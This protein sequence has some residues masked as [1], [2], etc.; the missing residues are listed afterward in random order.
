MPDKL[1]QEC[2]TLISGC[3][4]IFED[5]REAGV[6]RLPLTSKKTP[7]APHVENAAQPASG[8]E[9][10]ASVPE[11]LAD[12]QQELTRCQGCALKEQRTQTVFGVGNPNARLVLIGEAPN[13]EE[14]KRGEPFVGETGQL[15][16]RILF[17]M[18][19][20][21]E[22]IYI[23]HL[24]KCK[25]PNERGPETA[26]VASCEDFL[27]RQLKIIA[28]EIILSLGGIATQ[29]LLKTDESIS[30]LRGR[31]QTYAGIPLMPT[32]HPADLLQNPAGKYQVWEDV[33]QVMHRLQD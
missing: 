11:T 4:A 28:P 7:A 2:R 21:R 1:Y 32:F 25:P 15:L 27:Q 22:D 16:D 10:G 18:K 13:A 24:V 17:A 5:L 19:L 33:K 9:S 30:K 29:A 26:E 8:Q 14:E 3:R 6:E 23:C 12:L 31:W 20:R